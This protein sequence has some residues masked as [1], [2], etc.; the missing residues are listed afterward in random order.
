MC[1]PSI[2]PVRFGSIKEACRRANIKCG[3]LTP[4]EQINKMKKINTK[5]SKEKI[6]KMLQIIYKND[7]NVCPKDLKKYSKEG[8]ICSVHTIGKYFGTVDN[9]FKKAG[10]DY[11]NYY[12]SNE[13][14]I[15]QLK[16]LND[17][18]GPLIK[19]DI[20]FYAKKGL[21]C[22]IKKIIDTFGSLQK[23]A[24]EAGFEFVEA[25]YVG[26]SNAGIGLEETAY[27]EKLQKEKNIKLISQFRLVSKTNQVYLIDAYDEENNVAYEYDDVSHRHKKQ[28]EKDIVRQK[29]IIDTIDCEFIRIK[30]Y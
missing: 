17:E 14:I 7:K 27:F 8:K 30:A 26:K 24:K 16:F 13:R 6:I 28:Q 19:S 11:K 1:H 9:L 3:A 10:I 12:W 20:T 18:H 29:D 22:R 15:K 21:I 2:I 4:I 25:Q 23:A 5:Y